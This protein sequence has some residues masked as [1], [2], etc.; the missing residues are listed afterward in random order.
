MTAHS[1][2]GAK[3]L[4]IGAT[5]AGK[6]HSL[7]TFIEAGVTPF[8]LFTEPGMR[9]VSD[10]PCDHLH[11]KYV[12]PAAPTWDGLIDNAK[13][14]NTLSFKALAQMG[15]IDKQ[16]YAQFL[17]VL[18]T[19]NDFVCDRCG[20]HFGDVAKWNTDRALCMDSLSGLNIM[21]M[22][23]VAGAKPVK[24]MGDWGV[25]M[26]NLE[27]YINT[28]TNNTH[29][30]FVLTAHAQ[31]ERDEITGATTI[32]AS[33]L[34]QKLA[35]KVPRFFDDVVFCRNTENKFTWSTSESN[36]AVKYRNLAPGRLLPPS[37]VPLIE[38][39]KKAGGII[40]ETTS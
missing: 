24:A 39:W 20:E 13:K 37:F 34:G 14:I 3:T 27:R 1:I 10:I 40:Q 26:D 35:P 9:T 30:H 36:I 7:R 33:T 16:K 11:Y 28:L 25:A 4:L 31:Q 23:L 15:D 19:M 22:D 17:E 12:P 29:C 38:S 32:M 5:G 2:P 6:T 18:T 21:A 8:I